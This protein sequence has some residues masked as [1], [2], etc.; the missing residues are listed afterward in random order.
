[1]SAAIKLQDFGR[2]L[3]AAP[4]ST[5]EVVTPVLRP[6]IRGELI[7]GGSAFVL[8]FGVLGLWA[9]TAQFSGAVMAPGV[10]VVETS[11]K[12]I[13]HPT[14]GLVRQI[15]VSN[16]SRVEAGDL[17][18]RLDDTMARANLA[19]ISQNLD[20]QTLRQLRLTAERE[21]A[22]EL[23]FPPD[24]IERAR[25]DVEF[26]TLVG[27]ER[28]VFELRAIARNGKR[29]Q[30][31]KRIEQAR[32]LIAALDMQIDQKE[33]ETTLL[34][35]EFETLSGLFDK[36]LIGLQRVNMLHRDT[37]RVGGEMA[38]LRGTRAETESKIAENELAI[39]QIDQ[40]LRSEVATELRDAQ[41][42]R[43]ELAERHVAAID[44]LEKTELRAPQAGIVQA[45]TAQKPGALVS[46]NEV[47]MSLVPV[48][49]RLFVD[50]Q[51]NPNEIDQI[52]PDQP[53]S[54][55]FTA[56]NARTTDTVEGRVINIS[57][58]RTVDPRD[59]RSASYAVRIAFEVGPGTSAQDMK[60]VPGMPVETFL[61]TGSRSF[62]SYLLKPLTD[63][64]SRAFRGR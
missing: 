58:D 64:M 12:K 50:C 55:R 8:L 51:V 44:A 57:A 52:H 27:G 16:G 30:L 13:Q 28:R 2:P 49:E 42:K 1:M 63:Q 29:E 17:L 19:I 56:F 39:I 53:A 23:V 26:A 43:K 54:L 21:G 38:Q 40:D 5:V 32:N 35:T 60:L 10:L 25:S 24:M 33:K 61:A 31:Q 15:F 36:K 11:T 62:L 3:N 20:E 14:G 34:Q 59:P 37:M 4:A 22:S 48:Q 18:V 47:V 41:A 6:S 46:A 7:A 9:G 45:L